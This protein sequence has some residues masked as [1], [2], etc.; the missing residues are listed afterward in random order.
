[1]DSHIET[2]PNVLYEGLN[3]KDDED[4]DS[5]KSLVEDSAFESIIQGSYNG[6]VSWDRCDDAQLRGAF[7]PKPERI[8]EV[9]TTVVTVRTGSGRQVMMRAMLYTDSRVKRWSYLKLCNV[10]GPCRNNR[11]RE[12][13]QLR[14]HVFNNLQT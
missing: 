13:K 11:V 5:R 2:D 14:K 9:A 10:N 3:S 4:L 7:F 12:I 1:M 6:A 8:G